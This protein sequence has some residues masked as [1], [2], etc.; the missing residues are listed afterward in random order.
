MQ[1]V[2]EDVLDDLQLACPTPEEETTLLCKSQEA[3]AAP[4]CPPRHEEWAPKPENA[5]KQME[6]VK[7]PQGMQVCPPPPGFE[8]LPPEQDIPFIRIPD[9]D[10]ARSVLM[11]VHTMSMVVY[12][13]DIMGNLK[14]EYETHYLE[15]LH[16]ES[17]NHRCKSLSCDLLSE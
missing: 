3:E 8:S 10:E 16:L 9:L 6:A 5:G 17:P 13:N 15:P 12:K 2:E 14:Y 4:A 11:P 1:F 7:E